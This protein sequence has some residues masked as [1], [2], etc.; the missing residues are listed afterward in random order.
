MYRVTFDLLIKDDEK[1][2][3]GGFGGR[4]ERAVTATLRII[5]K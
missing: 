4:R 3:L 5:I 1:V 2:A